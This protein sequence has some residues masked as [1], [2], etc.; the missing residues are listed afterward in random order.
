MRFIGR[1]D[2]LLVS[3]PA[4]EFNVRPKGEINVATG[5]VKWFKP[6]KGHGFITPDDR[7]PDVF[8]HV[9]AVR[10]AGYPE[11]LSQ[12]NGTPSKR[13]VP[14]SSLT[15]HKCDGSLIDRSGVT[16]G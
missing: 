7:G 5:T 15:A 2:F 10:K 13:Y 3:P 12:M 11:Y 14:Q 9:G 6:I 8:V 1:T 16:Q 4:R